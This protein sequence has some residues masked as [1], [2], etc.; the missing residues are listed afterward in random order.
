MDKNPLIQCFWN[1]IVRN[2]GQ[3]EEGLPEG[4]GALS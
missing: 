3:E 4:G 1:E 2:L